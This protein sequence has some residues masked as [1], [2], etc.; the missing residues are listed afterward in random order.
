[1]IGALNPLLA[2]MLSIWARMVALAMCRQ[3]QVN[4]YGMRWSAAMAMCNASFPARAGNAP[5]LTSSSASSSASSL[6]FQQG[7]RRQ[8]SQPFLGGLRVAVSR[9]VNDQ[10]RNTKFIVSTA[11]IPPIVRDLLMPGNNEVTAGA[12]S[13]V[14][15]EGGFNI[16]PL[17]H[18]PVRSHRIGWVEIRTA[19]SLVS[20]ISP[21]G[22]NQL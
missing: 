9:L 5:A 11:S 7:H 22:E 18:D 16:D 14:A 15:D 19:S 21:A 1:M 10:L 13:Q 17:K 8:N 12:G 3:F 6:D 2:H 4:R 20:L